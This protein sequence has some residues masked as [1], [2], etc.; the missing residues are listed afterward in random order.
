MSIAPRPTRQSETV[1]GRNIPVLTDLKN[2]NRPGCY[3]HFA[4][5]RLLTGNRVRHIFLPTALMKVLITICLAFIL[6]AIV[7]GQ[8]NNLSRVEIKRA[9][10]RLSQLGYWTGPIDGVFD[11]ASR[12]ALIAFQ[13]Y[14]RRPITGQMTIEELE[15]IRTS[16]MPSPKETGYAHVEVDLDRQL[17]L[18]VGDDDRVR[19]LPVSTGNDQPFVAEGQ[20]SIAYT[21]RGR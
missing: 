8:R 16:S 15:V 11:P 19:V 18:V 21:P 1:Y 3:K 20:T 7:L 14:E 13:K 5:P 6:P 10:Q 4:A 12:S 2:S 9:E 17:L